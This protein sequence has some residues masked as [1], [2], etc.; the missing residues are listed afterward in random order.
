M[1]G[2]TPNVATPAK[3]T[4]D[5]QNSQRWMRKIRRRSPTSNRPMAAAITTAASALLGRLASRLG[6]TSSSSA[7]ATAPT[8]PVTCVRAPA[9]SATGV[10]DE[11]LLI[12]NPW[13]SPAARLAA[14]R[15]TLAWLGAPAER[16]LA[17]VVR[18]STLVSANDTRATAQPPITTLPRSAREIHG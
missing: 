8:T 6:A 13:N 4:M 1:P 14:P 17:A 15:P 3:Q 2:I 18:D 16:F 11:L 9:A 10:R 5:S 12:G 7:T